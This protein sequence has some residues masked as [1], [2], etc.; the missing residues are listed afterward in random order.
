MF[1]NFNKFQAAGKELKLLTLAADIGASG[2]PTLA[3]SEG[4]ASIS[5]SSAGLYVL[6]IE[7]GKAVRLIGADAQLVDDTLADLTYQVSDD[8]IASAGTLS[9]TFKAAAVATDPASGS[10]LLFNILVKNSNVGN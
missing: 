7:G 2:A 9:I 5:R 6:T 1:Y 4:I 10:Q 8:S 3:Y